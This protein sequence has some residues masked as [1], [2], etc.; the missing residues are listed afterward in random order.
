MRELARTAPAGGL[1]RVYLVG[2]GTA[3]LSGWRASSVD[4]DLFSE[5]DEIFHDIQGIKDRLDVNVE[6]TRPEHFVPALEGTIDRHAFVETIGDVSFYHYDPYAQVLSKVVRG[7]QRDLHDARHFVESGMVDPEELL[8]LVER[9][10]HA[11][12]AK[13]PR[14]SRQAVLQAVDGFCRH[15]R[16]K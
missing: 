16:S 6:I 11:A 7:F 8:R 14:L 5:Q 15:I 12:Y 13:Y 9:I 2:G 10:P 3:V 1:Y 4:A